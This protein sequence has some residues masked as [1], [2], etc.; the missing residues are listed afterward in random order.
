L[1]YFGEVEESS[2][3]PEVEG[4]QSSSILLDISYLSWIFVQ[5]SWG[6]GKA[7]LQ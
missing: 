6:Y 1:L 7:W 5:N 2:S 3:W 4:I